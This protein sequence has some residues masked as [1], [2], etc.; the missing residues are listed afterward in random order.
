MA[1][2]ALR[3]QEPAAAPADGGKPSV[4][5]MPL[6]ILGTGAEGRP[7]A[8][9]I[10]E[11]IIT[12]LS[13]HRA[14]LVVARE[15]SY[16]LKGQR[17]DVRRI[18]IQ[19]AANYVLEGTVTCVG[20]DVRIAVQLAE[21]ETGSCIWAEHFD[22]RREDLDAV[23]EDVVALIAARVEP[24]IANAERAR[25][26][27]KSP[28]ARR[29]WDFFLL[30]MKH[31][32]RST[33]ADNKV[34]QKLLRRAVVLDTA[35]SQAHA[36]LAY[37]MVLAMVYF[38][39]EP[40][41][42]DLNAAVALAR[43]AVDLDERDALAHFVCGRVLLARKDYHGSISELEIAHQLNPNLAPV[44]CAL[45]DS[46]SYQGRFAEAMPYFDKAL[47][48]CPHDPQRWAFC[49]YR[50]LAHIFA[51]EDQQALQWAERALH[52]PNSLY[53]PYAHRVAAMGYLQRAAELPRALDELQQRKQGF[54]C[55]LAR[56]RLFYVKDPNHLMRY[57]EGLRR[58]GVAE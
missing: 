45:G 58:A 35:L 12:A 9:A 28:Q 48:L 27:R 22:R 8:D 34:A 23:Q 32:F 37:A 43:H 42:D 36:W 4:A 30:G 50:S 5:V 40:S 13:R 20:N 6:V 33:P 1:T 49:A 17:A 7:I 19:L 46:L 25:A 51:G 10:A 24:E 21:T 56:K 15:S 18:G 44:Y 3:L 41:D 39:A 47:T 16:A 52:A 31:L 2:Q 54:S 29:A 55:S 14:M 38:D 26:G 57:L 11:D 53:W